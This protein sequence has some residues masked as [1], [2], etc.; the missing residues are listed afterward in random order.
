MPTGEPP[1]FRRPAV[2]LARRREKPIAEIAH[3][4]GIAQSCLRRWLKQ[5]GIDSGRV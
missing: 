1:Q 4:L 5:E 3:D 2:D